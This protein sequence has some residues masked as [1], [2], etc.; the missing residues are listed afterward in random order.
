MFRFLINKLTR[1]KVSKI[2]RCPDA[3]LYALKAGRET[4][5]QWKQDE[6]DKMNNFR[7]KFWK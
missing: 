6:E 7:Q 1:V 2:D 4:Q 3:A 5:A